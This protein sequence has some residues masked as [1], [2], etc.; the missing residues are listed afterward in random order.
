MPRLYDTKTRQETTVPENELQ[1]ALA[2]G[3]VAFNVNDDIPAISP[4]GEPVFV[5]AQ[6]IAKALAQGFNIETPTQEA[7]R[8]YVKDNDTV[9]G[10]I[11][12]GLDQFANQAL[13]GVPGIVRD[14]YETPLEKLKREALVKDHE[15]SNAVGGT[16]GFAGSLFTG[17]PLFKG[18]NLAGQATE[19]ALATQLAEFGIKRGSESIAKDLAARI[20]GNSARLGVESVILSSPQAAAQALTGAPDLAAETLMAGGVL[21]AGLGI[22]GTPLMNLTKAVGRGA[23]NQIKKIGPLGQILEETPTKFSGTL[24]SVTQQ[25]REP[26]DDSLLASMG[27]NAPMQTKI[28]QGLSQLKPNAG[29]IKQSAEALGITPTEG[30]IS[31]SKLIQ[32]MDSALSKRVSSTG[33]KR[34]QRY[35]EI[36]GKLENAV[37]ESFSTD[38]PESAL[39]AGDQ[40]KKLIREGVEERYTPFN[41]A[42]SEIR[43]VTG[44]INIPLEDLNTLHADIRK[45]GGQQYKKFQSKINE[46]ADL[47]LE[48]EGSADNLD[49]IG[50]YIKDDI[51]DAMRSGRYEEMKIL[52]KVKDTIKDFADEG[53]A[54]QARKLQSMGVPGA[55]EFLQNKE[56][57]N[58]G[59][60]EFKEL[61]ET[62]SGTT[63]VRGHGI[64]DVL[65]SLDEVA[66]EKLVDRLFDKKN[67]R[68]MEF[69]QKEFPKAFD[70]VK[71]FKKRQIIEKTIKDNRVGLG[72]IFNVT[73]ADKLPHE[74]QSLIFTPEQR[75]KFDQARTVFE[76]LPK[77]VNPSGTARGIDFKEF[78][79]PISPSSWMRFA[80]ETV[81]DRLKEKFLSDAVQAKGL[82]KAATQSI[83][84]IS[85]IPQAIDS[86][87]SK[88]TSATTET[89][90]INAIQRFM[91]TDEKKSRKDQL[92]E[93]NEKLSEFTTNGAYATNNVSQ[94]THRM[95]EALAGSM[96]V[97]KSQ[98]A[99]YLN[100]TI[101]KPTSPPTPFNKQPWDPSDQQLSRFE[102]RVHA[103]NHPFSVIDDL[104]NGT[105]TKEAIESVKAIYPKLYEQIQQKVV[106]T[107]SDRDEKQVPYSARI[108][109]SLLMDQ[110]FDNAMKPQMIRAYQA[111]FAV[112]N[113]ASAQGQATDVQVPS[114]ATDIQ[115]ISQ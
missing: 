52:E 14:K 68:A 59:Y 12:V 9:S 84:Q 40:I 45:F 11:K 61:M 93:L 34:A 115:R 67:A 57:V 63:K 47:V 102:R 26:V 103:V 15:I 111:N 78:F 54:K 83:E 36:Y 13:F 62:L 27:E 100:A 90:S 74:V 48:K 51:S 5:P 79:N 95:D 105:L 16:A 101:P 112:A 85:K 32:D 28:N 107:L 64:K 3:K 41:K 76:S 20:A 70:I 56:I 87:L 37:R 55:A 1:Q 18:A 106:E 60:K 98:I 29:S 42:Y 25:A 6:N 114:M 110:P 91:G 89:S 38:A 35:E 99:K 8:T 97:K 96:S 53:I 72:Q 49:T 17:G 43:E 65:E 108:K 24:E 71:G 69:M 22:V 44:G 86:L 104:A 7:V 113:Q 81:G 92:K 2:D 21:G 82:A 39:Q 73:K 88:R 94:V 4:D 30:M 77:D 19:R 23:L 31:G 75:L 33:V 58:R 10:S 109:L 66:S 50:R 46:Y 80:G